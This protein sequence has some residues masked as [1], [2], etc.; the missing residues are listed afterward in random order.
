[1]ISE[2]LNEICLGEEKEK[3]GHYSFWNNFQQKLP[4][5]QFEEFFLAELGCDSALTGDPLYNSELY[6]SQT[7]GE[8]LE[9]I[10]WVVLTTGG[11][12]L[13]NEIVKLQREKIKP[14]LR[15]KREIFRPTY[16]A[17]RSIGYTHWDIT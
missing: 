12:N 16:I 15:E 7:L 6:N 5:G 11:E 10:N 17:L 8:F 9:T 13:R 1:M 14:G 2:I 4:G 3:S